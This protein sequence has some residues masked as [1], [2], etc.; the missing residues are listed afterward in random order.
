MANLNDLVRQLLGGVA[1]G[2]DY[3]VVQNWLRKVGEAELAERL[4]LL[5]GQESLRQSLERVGALDRGELASV[6]Q[7]LL[8]GGG[9]IRMDYQELVDRADQFFAEERYT[10][11]IEYY[12]LAIKIEEDDY[13]SWKQIGRSLLYENNEEALKS[14]D[15]SIELKSDFHEAWYGRGHVLV[16]LKRYEKALE[17]LDKSIEM[18]SEFYEAWNGRG[19]ALCGMGRYKEALE[20]YNKA[21]E[22][23]SDYHCAWDGYGNALNGMGRYEEALE[24]YNKAIELKPDNHLC[25]DNRSRVIGIL[26]GHEAQIAD[27]QSALKHIKS[28]THPVGCGFLHHQI[29]LTYY[30]EGRQRPNESYNYANQ[31]INSYHD[32]L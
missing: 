3:G 32:A 2:W 21:I 5:V 16:N 31:A 19:H 20:S 28:N 23:Q 7:E 29:G 17:S 13:N 24:S 18:K 14:F 9:A 11:A 10:K 26:H 30:Q 15:K 6:A 25:W 12:R 4:R 22:L 1:A 8:A 27:Y